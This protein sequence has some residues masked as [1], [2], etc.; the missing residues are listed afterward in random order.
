M[1]KQTPMEYEAMATYLNKTS[2]RI[3][4]VFRVK[5]DDKK[6][7]WVHFSGDL[8]MNPEKYKEV[9]DLHKGDRIKIII[10]KYIPD[11]GRIIAKEV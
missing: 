2:P 1:D 9:F 6:I 10:N 3:D 8:R 11:R 7:V 4:E 5:T